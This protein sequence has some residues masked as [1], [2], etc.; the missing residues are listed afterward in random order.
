[1]LFSTGQPY[2]NSPTP[3]SG[4]G[5]AFGRAA[6]GDVT[7]MPGRCMCKERNAYPGPATPQHPPDPRS[8]QPGV[9]ASF[10]SPDFG[11]VPPPG[12][13]SFLAG[14][15]PHATEAPAT[16]RFRAQRLFESDQENRYIFEV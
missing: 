13:H 2:A 14:G 16:A 6:C 11:K 1:M 5:G 3:V 4:I 9:W 10:L 15:P 12:V 7:V 8:R